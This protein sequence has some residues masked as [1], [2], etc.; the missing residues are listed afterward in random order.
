MIVTL[1]ILQAVGSAEGMPV[2][3]GRE[4][5]DGKLVISVVSSSGY[6]GILISILRVSLLFEAWVII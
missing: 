6:L 4:W 2:I 5:S 3:D 1:G